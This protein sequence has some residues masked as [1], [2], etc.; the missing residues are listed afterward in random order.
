LPVD[1]VSVIVFF[2]PFVF[3]RV[4]LPVEEVELGLNWALFPGKVIPLIKTPLGSVAAI[5]SSIQFP[6]VS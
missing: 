1:V 5:P 2:D 6:P 3:D 4:M